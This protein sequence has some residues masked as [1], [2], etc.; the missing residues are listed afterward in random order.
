M[1][2]INFSK[3]LKEYQQ[4]HGIKFTDSQLATLIFNSR[5]SYNEIYASLLELA[6]QT[7]DMDLKEQIRRRTEEMSREW[8]AFTTNKGNAIYLLKYYEESDKEYWEQGYY[9]AFEDACAVGALFGDKYEIHKHKL[10]SNH[11]EATKEFLENEFIQSELGRA[12]YLK[13]G[14]LFCLWTREYKG[15]T[16]AEQLFQWQYVPIK[17][18]F[19]KGD[20]VQNVLTGEIGVMNGAATDEEMEERLKMRTEHGDISDA[21]VFVEFLND[22]GDFYHEHVCPTELDF[23]DMEQYEGKKKA[24]LFHASIVVRGHGSLEY[25]DMLREELKEKKD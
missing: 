19:R 17:Y 13:D 25:L 23:F 21:T 18:P 14:S 22:D 24:V 10:F 9:L 2:E 15:D 20:I 4:K 6:A 5:Y 11:S 1:V 7:N 3:G 8:K 16:D 12:S